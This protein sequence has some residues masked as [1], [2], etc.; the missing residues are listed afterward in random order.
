MPPSEYVF[1][2]VDTRKRTGRSCPATLS[3]T[4]IPAS[5]GYCYTIIPWLAVTPFLLMFVIPFALYGG[6]L[7]FRTSDGV[8]HVSKA[9]LYFAIFICASWL[10]LAAISAC[11]CASCF[12]AKSASQY[13]RQSEASSLFLVLYVVGLPV[14][15]FHQLFKLP[16][17]F[18]NLV[19]IISIAAY[20]AAGL[21]IR[22]MFDGERTAEPNRR[23]VEL[24]L[25]SLLFAVLVALPIVLGK[26]VEVAYASAVLVAA[27]SVARVQHI[28]RLA[29][30]L[31]AGGLVAVAMVVKTPVRQLFYDGSLYSRIDI[32]DRCFPR[33]LDCLH[34]R[35]VQ[36]ARSF[37][38][39]FDGDIASFS[40]YD[41]NFDK[42]IFSTEILGEKS[43]YVLARIVHRVN[44]LGVLAHAVS[45]TPDA[46]P[47]W[48]W[49][50]YS[51]MPYILIPRAVWP[52]KPQAG[53]ANIFGRQ[54][55]ILDQTDML[56]TANIDPV[57]EA[58]IDGGW[59]AIF[60][61]SIAMG[62][63]LGGLLRWLRAG[64]DQ[65]IRFLASII[66][67]INLAC[68]ESEAAII[69]GSLFQELAFLG[70]IMV[71][72]RL[73]TKWRRLFR[74]SVQVVPSKGS[75]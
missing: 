9:N 22:L 32:N 67:A 60:L 25:T 20:L 73:L 5:R 23:S 33:L 40:S 63:F 68:F 18:E 39:W 52:E 45:V 37:S 2:V 49:K 48:G 50:T 36:P 61:S 15:A 13:W 28:N 74:N 41:P 57:T 35:M 54:Y 29:A 17:A 71:V 27:L 46:I 8:Y 75:Y 62:A 55:Q 43:H 7:N 72:F 1:D 56:T 12:K 38:A 69:V 51:I 3:A 26:A 66:V 30:V 70:A 47:F 11:L 19:H 16:S 21:G 34:E 6:D 65:E 58:W 53:V 44:H 4:Q 24:A 64:G 14:F 59:F 42:I 31:L 10:S